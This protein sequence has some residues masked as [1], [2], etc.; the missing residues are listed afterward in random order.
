MGVGIVSG[1]WEMCTLGRSVIACSMGTRRIRTRCKALV[2]I[3]SVVGVIAGTERSSGERRK[4]DSRERYVVSDGWAVRDACSGCD[5]VSVVRVALL[6]RSEAGDV[7]NWRLTSFTILEIRDMDDKEECEDWDV[8]RDW[9]E[10]VDTL[11]TGGGDVFASWRFSRA[12]PSLCT[13]TDVRAREGVRA[14]GAGVRVRVW[15]ARGR[16]LFFVRRWWRLEERE[17]L[18]G[19]REGWVGDAK[20]DRL[21]DWGEEGCAC[22]T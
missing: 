22:G 4:G 15:D 21:E 16:V 19:W 20:V 8:A 2:R 14:S 10:G 17:R 6:D 5:G 12:V 3:S 11:R 13:T 1:Y 18:G 9:R 7:W